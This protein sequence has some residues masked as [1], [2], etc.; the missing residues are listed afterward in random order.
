[1]KKYRLIKEYPGSPDIGYI[2]SN[3]NLIRLY[4]EYPEHW[5]EVIESDYEVLE[6]SWKDKMGIH[7]YDMNMGASLS[8]R[9]Y[10]EYKI[11]SVRRLSD[12]EVFTI[13]DKVQVNNKGLT[14]EIKEIHIYQTVHFSLWFTHT[15]CF[16][17]NPGPD[18]IYKVKKPLFTTEAGEKI[19]EGDDVYVTWDGEKLH[20]TKANKC[21]AGTGANKLWGCFKSKEKAES[22]LMGV[23]KVV[24]LNEI[25][26]AYYNCPNG[27][28]IE[29]KSIIREKLNL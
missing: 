16:T 22:F 18:E 23:S 21:H 14:K 8:D 10:A 9:L 19:Y 2:T 24:S 7:V 3:E 25:M 27:F 15:N 13:G 11:H 12:G 1:M 28:Y 6:I 4:R 20:K 17:T 5:E 26:N 29:I